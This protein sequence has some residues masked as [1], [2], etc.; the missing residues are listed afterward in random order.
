MMPFDNEN[1]MGGFEDLFKQFNLNNNG[2]S[3]PLPSKAPAPKIGVSV[4]D[5]AD[6]EGV[7]VNDVT[8]NSAASKAGIKKN[9]VITLFGTM[10]IT[11][12]DELLDAISSNQNKSKVPVE[13]KR[14]GTTKKLEIEIPKALK[15]K[16]L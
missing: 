10:Q 5:R 3:S 4:E 9:D 11:N 1:L 8:D 6:G 7:F 16:E 15:K 2:F 14:N 12:V 13:I